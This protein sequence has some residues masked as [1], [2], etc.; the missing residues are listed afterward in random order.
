MSLGWEDV[1]IHINNQI[2]FV[3]EQQVQVFERLGKNKRIHSVTST[4]TLHCDISFIHSQ[5][6]STFIITSLSL[7]IMVIVNCTQAMD[8]TARHVL[9]Y[10]LVLMCSRCHVFNCCKA[11][12]HSGQAI[13]V[14][15]NWLANFQ[16]IWITSRLHQH[17]THDIGVESRAFS[18]NIL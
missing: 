15:N 4:F 13:Q 18:T 5:F 1:F 3:R 11:T 2:I 10:A 14:L 16:I 9:H 8:C 7:I 17:S 12:W 6:I